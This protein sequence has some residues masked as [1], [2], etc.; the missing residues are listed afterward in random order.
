M[1]HHQ[2]CKA[3]QNQNMCTWLGAQTGSIVLVDLRQPDLRE[4]H[5]GMMNDLALDQAV[6]YQDSI[7]DF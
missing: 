2:E 5:V 6:F 1:F 3:G 7:E 4:S